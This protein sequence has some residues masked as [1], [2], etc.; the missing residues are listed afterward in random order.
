MVPSDPRSSLFP[1]RHAR[2][3]H[4][5]QTAGSLSALLPSSAFGR[6]G[7]TLSSAM[8]ALSGWSRLL[9]TTFR[10]PAATAPFS[11]APAAGSPFPV[12]PF[13]ATP[14]FRLVR[15]VPDSPPRIRLRYPGRV[16]V[17]HPFPSFQPDSSPLRTAFAPLRAFRPSGSK[18]PAAAGLR[19]SPLRSARSPF[20]PRLPPPLLVMVASGSPF[21]VRYLPPG[22]LFLEP[23]GTNFMMQQSR[24]PVKQKTHFRGSF[25]ATLF[26]L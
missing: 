13:A 18:H 12:Y 5:A 9:G 25:P 7:S 4:G 21:R 20:A 11:E 16:S 14:A 8:L 17:R 19:D 2:P 22:S 1:D 24:N 6:S 26:H 3:E 10:S 23:L 15:S